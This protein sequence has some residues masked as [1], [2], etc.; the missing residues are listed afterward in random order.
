MGREETKL[1]AKIEK[2]LSDRVFA[3]NPLAKKYDGYPSYVQQPE[4]ILVS[5]VDISAICKDL[6]K[7]GGSELTSHDGRPP[8]FHAAHSSSAL[9]ANT[10]GPYRN[11]PKRLTVG[12]HGGFTNL[13]FESQCPTGAGRGIANLDVLLKGNGVVL[14]V[15]SKLIETLSRKRAQFSRKKYDKVFENNSKLNSVWRS[16]YDTLK[17]QEDL[18]TYLDAAQLVKHYL[19]LRQMFKKERVSLVYLYWQPL[20]AK[21]FSIYQK[22]ADEIKDLMQRLSGADMP[23]LAISYPELWKEMASSNPDHVARLRERYEFSVEQ[24]ECAEIV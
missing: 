13:Q 22:H 20:N 9:A 17:D 7:G 14:G 23:L 4:Q 24:R 1:K 6:K 16:V 18:Y 19:G 12:G 8:K 2:V 5:G 15:E 3:Q 21:S 10:F 11:E